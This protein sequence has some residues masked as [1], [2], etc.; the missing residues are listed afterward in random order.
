MHS[1]AMATADAI[2]IWIRCRQH[3]HAVT[4][5]ASEGSAPLDGGCWIPC[6]ALDAAR[7]GHCRTVVIRPAADAFRAG[8]FRCAQHDGRGWREAADHSFHRNGP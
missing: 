5:S 6:E 1:I 3:P 4:L 8:M 2:Q 7:G